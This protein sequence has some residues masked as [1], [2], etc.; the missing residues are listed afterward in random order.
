MNVLNVQNLNFVHKNGTVALRD[1][2]ISVNPGSRTLIIGSNGAGKVPH[3]S[4]LY[5]PK[6]ITQTVYITPNMW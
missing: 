2:S 4:L 5:I 1:L 6:L 3:P